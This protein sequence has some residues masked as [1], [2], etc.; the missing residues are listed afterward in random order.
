[1]V[2][3]ELTS[4]EWKFTHTWLIDLYESNL[5]RNIVYLTEAATR[6]VL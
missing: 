6:G 5:S 3:M 1:M 2:T 4:S